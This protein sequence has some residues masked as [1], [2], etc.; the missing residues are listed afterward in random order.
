M[1]SLE[2]QRGRKGGNRVTFPGFTKSQITKEAQKTTHRQ[3][4]HSTFYHHNKEICLD[5]FCFLHGT[6]IVFHLMDHG[7]FM[8]Q[9]ENCVQRWHVMRFVQS[10]SSYQKELMC[11]QSDILCNNYLHIMYP[12]AYLW[13][14]LWLIL[15]MCNVYAFCVKLHLILLYCATA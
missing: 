8:N 9:S 15:H 4:G 10:P 12:R 1:Q 3:K 11:L 14:S 7:V 5:T 13:V 2:T 6:Y